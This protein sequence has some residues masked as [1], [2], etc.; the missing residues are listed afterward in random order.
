MSPGHKYLQNT[1]R[2]C[3]PN[4]KRA[5]DKRRKCSLKKEYWVFVYLFVS[6]KEDNWFDYV[7][8]LFVRVV[9]LRMNTS[10]QIN[11]CATAKSWPI[12]F[13]NKFSYMYVKSVYFNYINWRETQPCCIARAKLF[14]A[15]FAKRKPE[16]NYR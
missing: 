15:P 9:S 10:S 3:F 6:E 16:H 7:Y 1:L 8:I 11:V 2:V 12:A 13:G 5:F 14:N 4:V